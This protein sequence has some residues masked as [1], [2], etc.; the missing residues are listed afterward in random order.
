MLLN[1]NKNEKK[2]EQQLKNEEEEE[3][4]DVLARQEFQTLNNEFSSLSK[5]V[6][7]AENDIHSLLK[8]DT[9]LSKRLDD[10]KTELN[11]EK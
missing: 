7:T 4:A 1:I 5:N 2:L 11:L 6:S 8:N 3:I 9:S 10:L